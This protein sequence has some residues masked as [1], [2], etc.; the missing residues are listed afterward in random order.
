MLEPSP[1]KA[2]IKKITASLTFAVLFVSFSSLYP[3]QRVKEQDFLDNTTCAYKIWYL[4]NSMI[5]VRCK[6]YYAW[7]FADAICN[8]SGMGYNGRDENGND[9]WDLISN[10]DPI[11]FELSLSLK[12]AISAWN[13]GTNR[14]LRMIVYDRNGPFKVFATNGLSAL[15]HGF[16]PGY[17]LTFAT[18]ALFTH[19]ARAVSLLI[20]NFITRLKKIY[21]FF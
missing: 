7:L 8:N 14:W 20:T 15:W 9:R 21:F 17:Y 3:I 6:Y 11:K 19:A 2:V 16:Y 13:I 4:M 12:D 10:V 1:T 5:F 18:G